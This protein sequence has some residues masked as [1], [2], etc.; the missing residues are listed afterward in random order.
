M[1]NP[2]INFSSANIRGNLQGKIPYFYTKYDGSGN[3]LI[4][5]NFMYRHYNQ[6]QLSPLVVNIVHDG[7]IIS[8]THYLNTFA[9]HWINYDLA[10]SVSSSTTPR[11][12]YN[13]VRSCPGCH[14]HTPTYITTYI[15]SMQPKCIIWTKSNNTIVITPHSKQFNRKTI[16]N[17]IP[18]PFVILTQSNIH[19]KTLNF[20]DYCARNNTSASAILPLNPVNDNTP[21]INQRLIPTTMEYGWIVT[22]PDY[23]DLTMKGSLLHCKTI[24][25]LI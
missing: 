3:D 22:L 12:I 6:L 10:P 2:F 17:N 25:K 7:I 14:L 11:S 1:I 18:K 21:S 15:G 8:S 9:E 4:L 16:F 20:N 23:I 19:L 13:V 24:F 5:S